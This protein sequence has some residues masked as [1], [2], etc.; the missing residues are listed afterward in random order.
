M[1]KSYGVYLIASQIIMK[2][3]EGT[4]DPDETEF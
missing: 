2:L 1:V 3:M 4:L